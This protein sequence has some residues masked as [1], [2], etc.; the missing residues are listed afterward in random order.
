[1]ASILKV[2]TL[3]KPDGSTPTAADLGIDV[4]GSVVQTQQFTYT[5]TT[6]WTGTNYVPILNGTVTPKHPDSKFLITIMMRASHT[7]SNSLYFVVGIN[8][9]NDLWSQGNGHPSATGSIYMETYG[10]GH[11]SNAQIDEYNGQYLYQHSGVGDVTIAVQA[12]LQGGT[13]YMNHAYSYNDYSRGR[14]MS[15]LTVQEI[16]Q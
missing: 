1:M 15:I 4:A 5:G 6:S 2:D 14:P 10:D 3:Q 8:N 9:N 13:G 12:K 11:S 16:A 7:P